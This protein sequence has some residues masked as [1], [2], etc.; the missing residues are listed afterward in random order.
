[1]KYTTAFFLLWGAFSCQTP[2]SSDA[3]GNFEATE[4]I[5]SAESV[6]KLVQFLV[7]EGTEVP[8]DKALGIIDTTQLY[9]QKQ[10]LV[11]NI[12]A[13]KS[14]IQDVKVQVNVLREQKENLLREQKRLE[15]LFSENAATRKQLDDINGEVQVVDSRILATRSQMTTSNQGILSEI[16]PLE[17]QVAR[18]DDQMKKSY[19]TSPLGGTVITKYAEQGEFVTLGKPVFKVANLQKMTL[20]VYLSG[21]QLAD[22]SLGQEVEVL[23]DKDKKN[24]R[25]LPGKVTWISSQAEFTPKIIQTKEERVNL[26]YAMKISV[27]NDGTLKIGMPGEV[28]FNPPQK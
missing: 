13:L 3:Y 19:I 16:A 21:A 7:E 10:Q 6:G 17:I 1:M 5:V 9:L 15:N 20:R 4:I 28:R 24:N 8:R 23:I 27:A 26:V 18:L 22:I 14:K 25:S 11:Y 12:A 2:D